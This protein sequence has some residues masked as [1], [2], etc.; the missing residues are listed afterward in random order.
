MTTYEMHS[1]ISDVERLM[2]EYKSHPAV[3]LF[4]P[5]SSTGIYVVLMGN[6]SGE[7][8]CVAGQTFLKQLE[9]LITNRQFK[10]TE[11]AS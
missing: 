11:N 10:G 6:P 8:L 1:F 9:R 5:K 7:W 2:Q 3:L 4:Q